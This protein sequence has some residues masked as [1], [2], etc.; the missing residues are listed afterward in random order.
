M[1]QH[2]PGTVTWSVLG[3]ATDGAWPVVR[4]LDEL[5][6]GVRYGVLLTRGSVLDVARREVH[7]PAMR[8]RFS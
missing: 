5:S 3:N 7:S 8:I 4:R 1:S 2:L 6:A